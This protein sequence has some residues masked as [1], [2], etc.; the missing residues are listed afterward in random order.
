MWQ[1][2]ANLMLYNKNCGSPLSQQETTSALRRIPRVNI[3]FFFL[4]YC[5]IVRFEISLELWIVYKLL[6]TYYLLRT[7]T[8]IQSVNLWVKNT[9]ASRSPIGLNLIIVF[10]DA[11]IVIE[12]YSLVTLHMICLCH[13]VQCHTL[14]I[15]YRVNC[16]ARNFVRQICHIVT[17]IGR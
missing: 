9:F 6:S 5:N 7:Y 11:F 17:S 3:R 2:L 14:Y 15:V 1:L 4:I 13:N 10:R 16:Y 12:R 8:S